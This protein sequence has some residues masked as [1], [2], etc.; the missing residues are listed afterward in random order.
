[1]CGAQTGY[2]ES[3]DRLHLSSSSAKAR[4]QAG[5]TELTVEEIAYGNVRERWHIRLDGESL[6]WT[7]EQEWLAD[8]E[9]ADSFL[10]AL[11]FA[12]HQQ[13]GEATVFELWD[14]D[15]VCDGFYGKTK[16]L[17]SAVADA[18]RRT[19]GWENGSSIAKLL[20]HARPNGDLRVAVT[21][22]LKKGEIIN[23]VSLL[24]QTLPPRR[25]KQGERVS[26]TMTLQPVAAETGIALDVKLGG[27]L[28]SD[29]AA[30]R[31]FF[32][33]HVNCAILA[34]TVNWRFGN[35]PTGY[36]AP[37]CL[38]MPSEM[39][40]F[41]VV[42]GALGPDCFNA[43][44]VLAGEVRMQAECCAQNGTIGQGYLEGTSLD[45]WPA[46]LLAARDSLL[47][48]GD[49]AEAERLWPGLQRAVRE[50][51]RLLESGDGLIFTMRDTGNDYWDWIDRNGWIGYVNM[52]AHAGMRAFEEI[53]RWLGRE[54]K[55]S[56]DSVRAKFNERFWDEERGYYADWIDK[57]GQSQFYL[58]AGP[59]LM[60][61]ATGLVPP[62]RAKRV[63]D[64]IRRRRRELGAAW[65]NCF[66]L[67]TNFYD[68]EKFS[69][70]WRRCQSDVT[71]FG[72]TMNG[73]C[74]VSWTYYWVGALAATGYVDEAIEA[75]RRVVHRFRETSL[76]EGCNYWDFAGQPSRTMHPPGELISYEPFLSDQGLVAL[77]LPR[78]LLGIEPRFDGIAVHPVLPAS[79]YPVTVKLQHL[80]SEKTIHIAG[81]S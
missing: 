21:G 72:Q 28:A 46:F 60:G 32:D 26:V 40:K 53:A 17:A 56:A 52:Q 62:D 80:G 63:I 4:I 64:A 57:N 6:L 13:W 77:A 3:A 8:T 59:Q 55:T 31:R 76:V 2:F 35:E 30:N 48:S 47:I 45:Q 44:Q 49:R 20:S 65:E 73:G 33:T 75:W 29:T 37:L 27:E 66:S 79:A 50:L 69:S 54:A 12:A 36:V 74:L 15:I 39:L 24:G 81:K 5:A 51:D 58:Y 41:G 34:D 7:V 71:R 16:V 70:V 43:H 61:I 78:W 1:V 10:P 11:F 23:Y 9:V 18:S 68:A 25:M 42:R 38:W 22:H 19:T 14:R 67:Q